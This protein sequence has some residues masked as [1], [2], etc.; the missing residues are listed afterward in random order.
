MVQTT[1]ADSSD[2]IAESAA[3]VSAAGSST[4]ISAGSIVG[5]EGAGRLAGI[6]PIVASGAGVIA[7]RTATTP[8]PIRDPGIEGWMRG[9]ISMH[10]A[11]T[12]TAPSAQIR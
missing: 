5:S 12:A 10:A 1:R 11:T 9:A 3:T 7:A 2:S 4:V 6:A 8:M